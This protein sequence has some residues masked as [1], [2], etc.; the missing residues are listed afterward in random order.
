MQTKHCNGC[1]RDRDVSCFGKHRDGLRH[2][3]RDCLNR[4]RRERYASSEG[5]AVP[6]A[7]NLEAKYGITLEQY[8]EMAKQQGNLCALC[9]QPE[10]VIA[11]SGEV[12]RL[13]VDHDHTTGE[14]RDLLCQRCNLAL[15]S[16]EDL[17]IPIS[18]L[19]DYLKRHLL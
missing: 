13:A 16:I 4:E 3:C 11:K 9:H 10:T 5:S 6:Y 7:Q 2:R 8:E 15:G 19:I 14:V 1:D 18:A 17:H 12:Q